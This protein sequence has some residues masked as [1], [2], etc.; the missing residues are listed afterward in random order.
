M[1]GVGGGLSAYSVGGREL[2][3]GYPPGAPSTSGRGQVL[4]PWPNRLED[5]AYEFDGR[6]TSSR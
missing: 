2:V 3:D 4:M 6:A 1:D 5:G